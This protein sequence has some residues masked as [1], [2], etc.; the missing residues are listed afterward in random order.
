MTK[1]DMLDQKKNCRSVDVLI[2]GSGLIGSSLVCA[3]SSVKGA[4]NLSV[5]IVEAG[6]ARDIS[7]AELDSDRDARSTALS[8][9][10]SQILERL[11][12]W[13]RLRGFAAPIHE[14]VVSDQGRFGST[15][16]TSTE[17]KLDALG[18]V[19]ENQNLLTALYEVMQ[20]HKKLNVVN[21]TRVVKVVPNSDGMEVQLQEAHQDTQKIQARLVV[22][23]E[24]GQSKIA[25]E[26]GIKGRRV[27]YNQHAIIANITTE[28]AHFGIAYERFSESG[29]IALLPL[30]SLREEHRASLVWTVTSA[31][32]AE[33]VH[34]TESM[35]IEELQKN[36]GQK[37]GQIKSIG[38]RDVFP[39]SLS[40]AQEQIRPSLVLLG[41]AAHTIH[42]VA[43]Q[44][45]N[46]S[47]RDIEALVFCID[48]GLKKDLRIN[49]FSILQEYVT[50]RD[51]D[52][53][54]VINFTHRLVNLFSSSSLSK[55]LPRKLGLL[56]LD[57]FPT[58]RRELV[59]RASGNR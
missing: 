25:T 46:L 31:A 8:F 4:A 59:M 35:L 10:S 18:Y 38:K 7:K 49:D 32:A 15:R 14:I 23:A 19:V 53:N 21:N 45:M 3:L 28:R 6:P 11:G 12:L 55:V 30:T 58:L 17:Y 52:Q 41:N 24:G 2:V 48:R 9:G 5:L 27:D 34:W 26:L 43:G 1:T 20:S 51:D 33:M 42:P 39:L 13:K 16:L 56:T 50:R 29:P 57:L 37:L 22:L 36:I 44:G 47:L 40:V 54:Q